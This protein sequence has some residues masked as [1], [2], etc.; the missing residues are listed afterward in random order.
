MPHH[1]FGN[2]GFGNLNAQLEQLTV[3]AWCTSTGIVAAH[4]PDQIPYLL[5]H[6]GPTRLTATDS[7]R[8]EQAKAFT[9]PRHNGFSFDDHQDG[10]PI[11]PH[12]SHLDPK[13]PVGGR[14]LQAFWSRST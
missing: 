12:S 6:T 10:F 8:P 13:D 4:Y 9:M 5:R 11:A 3:N 2:G 7:P 1:V 14:Q